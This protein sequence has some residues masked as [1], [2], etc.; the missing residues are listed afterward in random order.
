MSFLRSLLRALR[1]KTLPRS[2][3]GRPPRALL[4]VEFLEPRD[5]PTSSFVGR[6]LPAPAPSP[7]PRAVA[8]PW[9]ARP[10]ADATSSSPEGL[11]SWGASG[12]T[13]PVGS[14]YPPE[15]LAGSRPY[16]RRPGPGEWS[17]P[18]VSF[19]G[20]LERPVTAVQSTPRPSA[21]VRDLTT[22]AEQPAT[23]TSQSAADHQPEEAAVERITV[24]ILTPA[25]PAANVQLALPVPADRSPGRQPSDQPRAVTTALTQAI[26]LGALVTGAQ[27]PPPSAPLTFSADA[28]PEGVPADQVLPLAPE[29]PP[30]SGGATERPAQGPLAVPALAGLVTPAA[31][32]AGPGPFRLLRQFF[33]QAQDAGRCLASSLTQFLRSPWVVGTAA[34]LAALDVLRRRARRRAP[35]ATE[36]PEITGP[37]GL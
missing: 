28:S 8:V 6:A 27:G 33:P 25:A 20:L 23:P 1:P 32:W 34:A 11:H 35:A 9:A 14:T 19:A 12:P 3:P 26:P 29:G 21:A 18:E 37:R 13:E 7:E 30:P 15:Y 24:V 10:S 31:A 4:W 5:L 36:L 22:A 16:D 17:H 2:R